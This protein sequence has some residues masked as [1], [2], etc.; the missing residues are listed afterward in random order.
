MISILSHS[1]VSIYPF[2]TVGSY[3][4]PNVSFCLLPRP[5][6]T[7][8]VRFNASEAMF[9]RPDSPER[10]YISPIMSFLANLP[11]FISPRAPTT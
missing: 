1:I 2:A 6:H 9:V 3:L 4:L 5:K 8:R 10:V 7:F 11:L